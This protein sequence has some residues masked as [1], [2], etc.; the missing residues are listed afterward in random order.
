LKFQNEILVKESIAN[1]QKATLRKPV[2]GM[3]TDN[4][5]TCQYPMMLDVDERPASI[6]GQEK[7]MNLDIAAVE[8]DA[9]NSTVLLNNNNN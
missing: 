2:T 4:K 3:T 7:D 1:P 5:V 6:L 8:T 9:N